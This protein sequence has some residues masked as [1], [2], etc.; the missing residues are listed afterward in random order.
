[1]GFV[2]EKVSL[3]LFHIPNYICSPLLLSVRAPYFL[4]HVAVTVRGKVCSLGTFQKS[5]AF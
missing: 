1:M 2:V 3:G 5:N 4:L